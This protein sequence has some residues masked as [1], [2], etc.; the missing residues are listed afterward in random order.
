MKYREILINQLKSL[1]FCSKNDIIAL[2]KQF[3][4]KANTVNV[5]ISRSLARKDLILLKNGWYVTADFYGRHAGDISYTFYLANVLRQPSYVSSWSALQYYDLTTEAI[6]TVT[7][8]TPKITR[9]YNNRVGSFAYQAIKKELFTG[10][11]M[12]SGRPGAPASRF[13]FFIAT[14][15][16]ALFD[17]VYFRT[18]QF[19]WI[20][21]KAVVSLVER[22]RIDI[23]EMDA[24]E[25]KA[26]FKMVK[27]YLK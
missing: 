10:F 21:L 23:E 26:F 14:P 1:P 17:L 8:V 5:Y 4:L 15:A 7:S 27:G 9:T 25:R 22:L 12:V 16:K 20:D 13:N 18:N 2:G 11:T 3:G 6:G 19:H 24:K